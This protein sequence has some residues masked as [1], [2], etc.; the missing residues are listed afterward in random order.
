MTISKRKNKKDS[1]KSLEGDF[2]PEKSADEIVDDLKKSRAF[3]REYDPV[4]VAKILDG[5][6]AKEDGAKGLRVDVENMWEKKPEIKSDKLLAHVL[7]SI[8]IG[9]KQ[10]E[11]GQTIS[12]EEFKERHFHKK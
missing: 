11:N 12:F 5:V 3:T 1:L 4:F 8:E 6:K 9:I 7:K 2:I 10:Y